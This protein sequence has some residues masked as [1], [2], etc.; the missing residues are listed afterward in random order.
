[1]KKFSLIIF[2]F[3]LSCGYK[4]IYSSKNI[5]FSIGEIQKENTPLNNEFS[6]NL[7]T[8][9]NNDI[10]NQL[11]IKIESK[12][13]ITVKSKDTKGNPNLYELKI[14]LNITVYDEINGKTHNK[15]FSQNI[16][17]KNR[18][19]KFQLSQYQKEVEEL[20]INKIIENVLGYLSNI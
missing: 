2:I 6:R 16:N 18:D 10:A 8:F 5:N 11:K 3:L 7:K 4:P 19:D 1:M 15:K 9:S 20:L 12:K 17:Y 14:I 13:K